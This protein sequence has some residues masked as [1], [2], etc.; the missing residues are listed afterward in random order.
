MK[1]VRLVGYGPPGLVAKA[2]GMFE[3]I[4]QDGEV[5]GV[6]FIGI[7]MG[8]EQRCSYLPKIMPDG[9]L[10]RFRLCCAE[11]NEVLETCGYVTNAFIDDALAFR[12]GKG[13]FRI[14]RMKVERRKKSGLRRYILDIEVI[15]SMKK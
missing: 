5:R 7:G 14:A 9:A 2:A 15:E 11:A 8:R 1:S 13:P 12:S 4:V 3:L 6:N 10:C